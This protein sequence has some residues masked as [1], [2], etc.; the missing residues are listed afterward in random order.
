MAVKKKSTKSQDQRMKW[1]REAKF[2]LFIH[3]GL[4]AIPAGTWKGEQIPGI[5]EWIMNRARIPVREYERLANFFNPTKFDAEEWVQLA[6]DAGMKYLVIT[7]KHHDGFALFKSASAPYNIVDASPFTR[8]P[9]AELAKACKKAG[10][11]LCFYYSQKQDWHDPNASG[12]NWDFPDPSKQ[13]FNKYM[14]EKGL[15]QV[16]EILTQYGPIGL[17]WYDTPM[18][19]TRAQTKKFVDQVYAVQPDCLVNGRAGHGIG[20]YQSM[21]DNQIP[22]SG[23]PGDWEV[24]A[25]LNDTWGFK[26]YDRNW[27]SADGLI[28]RLVDIVSKGGNY[29]LNVGPTAHGV[30]PRP[31]ASRLRQ[32]GQ[33]LEKNGE[34]IY[35]TDPSPYPLEPTWGRIT[36]KKGKLFL[37]IF[38]WPG[39]EFV[40]H[41]LKSKVKKAYL[42]ADKR[43]KLLTCEQEHDEAAG[44]DIL[45]LSLPGRAPDSRVSVVVLEIQGDA[46]MDQTQ[47]QDGNGSIILEADSAQIHQARNS[48][49]LSRGRFGTIENWLN[50][51]NR[52]SWEFRM[53]RPGKYDVVVLSQTESDGRWEGG[54]RLKVSVGKKSASGTSTKKEVRDNP[55][56]TSHLR[57]V[58]SSIGKIEI[59]KPGLTTLSLKAET[60]VK[61]KGLGLKLR[62]VQLIPADA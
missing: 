40:L 50:A 8:D 9:I 23:V 55:R 56:A 1:W 3:W 51:G 12:N 14:R 35:G 26:S 11:K 37:H 48:A 43:K 45:R 13:N 20:D 33:W 41:G 54:H 61:K 53:A 44:L 62:A 10:I 17:I 36:A 42:L 2:G 27:K 21:G 4:Y 25:T 18:D 6:V 52:V 38:E 24:P 59:T 15:P 22:A 28:R 47:S 57:D 19:I 39:K 46:D 5:G 34:A 31:S 16:R 7:S 58:V 49:P 32:I 60:L 29:L 30:I